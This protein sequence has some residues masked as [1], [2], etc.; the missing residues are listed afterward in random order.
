MKRFAPILAIPVVAGLAAL[1]WSFYA[2][3][4][5]PGNNVY[6]G[7]VEGDLLFIGPNEGERLDKLAVEVGKIVAP[8]DALFSMATPLLDGQRAEAAGRLEQM[9][10]QFENLKASLNRPEQIAVLR[11]AVDRA[12]AALVLSSNELQRKTTLFAHGDATKAALDQASM[13]H[14][15]DK[16]SLEEAKRQVEAARLAGRSHEIGAAEAAILQARAQLS[17]IDIRI[18]RQSVTA[19]A[20]GVI[21]DVYFRPGEMVNAGQPVLS[22]L[23]PENRKVRFYVP[24][25]QLAAFKLGERVK[26]ACD[27]CADGLWGRISF[28]AAREEFTPP[29]IFSDQER[30]KL[31]FKLEAKLEQDAR[32]LPLG[33][34]VSIRLWQKNGGGGE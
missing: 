20:A 31:V 27:G 14:D 17:Q 30:N 24:E 25:P 2:S 13:A 1:S 9:T 3:G 23:P 4:G 8:G 12:Q 33:L 5:D 32:N 6:L 16:A 22:L 10:A 7:Y 19:P 26:V 29:V 15:R 34:P 11:A 18:A 28:M 21:Q